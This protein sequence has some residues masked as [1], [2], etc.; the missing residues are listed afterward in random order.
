MVV[1]SVADHYIDHLTRRDTGVSSILWGILSKVVSL[2]I[3]VYCNRYK[4]HIEKR[5]CA[6]KIEDHVT[7]APNTCQHSTKRVIM[8]C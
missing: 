3:R 7:Y 4:R 8:I 6:V 5:L 1:S 2:I